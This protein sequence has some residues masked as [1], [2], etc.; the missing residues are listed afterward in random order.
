VS[1]RKTFVIVGG[2][3]AGAKAVETLREEGFGPYAKLPCFFSDQHDLG[4]GR[5][6]P[7]PHGGRERR[8]TG[9]VAPERSG[10]ALAP[11]RRQT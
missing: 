8:E 6:R 11:D 4:M 2:G 3:L 7:D 9:G 5:D 10:P 1:D